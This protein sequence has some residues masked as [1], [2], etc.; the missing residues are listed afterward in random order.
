MGARLTFE[1]DLSEVRLAS[2]TALLLD[3]QDGGIVRT[4]LLKMQLLFEAAS[5]LGPCYNC[6]R[7]DARRN[8][9]LT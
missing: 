5:L 1:I 6:Y 3:W 4:E 8:C 7:A 9:T 2:R